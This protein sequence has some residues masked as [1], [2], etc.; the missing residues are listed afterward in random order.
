MA[1]KVIKLD[2]EFDIDKLFRQVEKMQQKP[3]PPVKLDAGS[4]EQEKKWGLRR[5]D[6]NIWRIQKGILAI[7]PD[8][9]V[10]DLKDRIRLQNGIN[11]ELVR[12]SLY[13]S[14]SSC[15]MISL[16]TREISMPSS[17]N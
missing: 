7:Y 15:S 17:E 8:K 13:L 9:G 10:P 2:N 12:G 16:L 4:K 5:M 14:L 11:R 3:E 1:P 6:L